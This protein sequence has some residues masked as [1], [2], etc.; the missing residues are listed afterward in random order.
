MTAETEA[1]TN[2]ANESL[3]FTNVHRWEERIFK[4]IKADQGAKCF[5][6]ITEDVIT[7]L[8]RGD[9]G[10][11]HAYIYIED[12][13]DATNIASENMTS[14]KDIKK[15]HKLQKQIRIYRELLR[16]NEIETTEADDTVIQPE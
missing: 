7:N 6:D 10:R 13:L 11:K 1:I 14:K 4:L 8:S 16:T 9:I 5:K 15:I 12:I 2:K 3:S